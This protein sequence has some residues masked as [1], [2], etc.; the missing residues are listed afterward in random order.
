LLGLPVP[1]VFCVVA[2]GNHNRAGAGI[3]WYGMAATEIGA[4]TGFGTI[5]VYDGRF[6]IV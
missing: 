2:G 3:I 5:D 6:F 4:A 1:H